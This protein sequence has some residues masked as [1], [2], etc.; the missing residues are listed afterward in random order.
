MP[1]WLEVIL[2]KTEEIIRLI[3]AIK[4]S[5]F[6]EFTLENEGFRVSLLRKKGEEQIT[7]S[8][9]PKTAG[10]KEIVPGTS[11]PVEDNLVE[12][13]APMVGT[14]YR[15]PS[16]GEEPFVKVGDTV[17]K[18]DTLCILEAMKLM[19]ELKADQGGEIVS[20]LVENGEMV[21][22]GQTLFQIKGQS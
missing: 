11:A 13:N 19:N 22:Y 21:E 6:T 4:N 17:K 7:S 15:A 14:F 20:I 9:P 16:P 12:V 2:I 1:F 8:P 18:D 10:G 3:E 5:D